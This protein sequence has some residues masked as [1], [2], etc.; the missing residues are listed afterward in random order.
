MYV[1][2]AARVTAIAVHRSSGNKVRTTHAIRNYKGEQLE[3]P[4][5]IWIDV[6]TAKPDLVQE[7]FQQEWD[8][9]AN[10]VKRHAIET[11]SY[12]RNNPYGAT[13]LPFEYDFTAQAEDAKM[14]GEYDD[15]YD[16]DFDEDL[17]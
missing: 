17:D 2:Y 1:R 13:L 14:S 10:Y 3:L 11:Q 9:V 12:D 4:G 6:R 16:D 8:G 7:V 15:S 5:T